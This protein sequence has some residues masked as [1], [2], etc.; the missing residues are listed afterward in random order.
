MPYY[1]KSN[2]L[3][4]IVLIPCYN[5][6]GTTTANGHPSLK[7][8]TGGETMLLE[9]RY[10]RLVVSSKFVLALAMLYKLLHL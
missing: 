4:A 5:T 8:N 7:L 10:F 3:F 1:Y 6:K 2:L 9:T